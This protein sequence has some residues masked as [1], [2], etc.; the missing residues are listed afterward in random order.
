MECKSCG[1]PLTLE[2][3]YC[4]FCGTKNEAAA[5]HIEDMRYYNRAFTQTQ[6]KVLK[7]S[8]W[9]SRYLAVMLA[10]VLAAVANVAVIV[11]E[12]EACNIQYYMNKW[13]HQHHGR[14]IVEKL[15][16]WEENGDY[17]RM[18]L[19]YDETG[20]AG[21]E[22]AEEFIPVISAYRDM[23]KLKTYLIQ[24][25]LASVTENRRRYSCDSYEIEGAAGCIV[26]LYQIFTQKCYSWYDGAFEG[27]HQENLQ[28]MEETVELWLKTYLYFTD[29]D[30]EEIFHMQK[31]EVLSLIDRR[32]PQHD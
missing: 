16:E 25:S 23:E 18:G 24:A 11:I 3:E 9:Y 13:Y 12:Q 6:Q 14:E 29:E 10:I 30:M 31:Y 28:K 27:I 8:K 32:A 4:P 1:S 26:D 21:L 20:F 17:A 19:Y 7:E 5:R 15:R 22:E 2:Q